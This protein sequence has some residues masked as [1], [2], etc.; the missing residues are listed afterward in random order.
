MDHQGKDGLVFGDGESAEVCDVED[1]NH[2]NKQKSRPFLRA[3]GV[4]DGDHTP[5]CKA[6]ARAAQWR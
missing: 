1:G 6:A 2:F 3:C 4:R 5:A